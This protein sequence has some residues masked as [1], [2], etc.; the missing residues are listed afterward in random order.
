MKKEAVIVVD[1]QNSFANKET[2]SLYVNWWENIAEAINE[3]VRE[4][5]AKWWIVITS[6]EIHP[7]WHI[8]FATSFEW[9]ESI[10]EAFKRW[11]A[12]SAKNF[13]TKDEIANWTPKNN[14]IAK[15]ASFNLQEL[16]AYLEISW[17]QALWPE[18]CVDKTPWADFYR[19]LDTTKIDIEIKK[20]YKP[21]SHPYSAFE[22]KTLDEKESTIEVIKRL[23]VNLVKVVWLATDYCDI[24]TVLDARKEGIETEFVEKA[25]AWV[26]SAWTI[27]ALKKMREVWAKI[28]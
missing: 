8:S 22:W 4:V 2:G 16:K 17:D 5:K 11:E 25:S 19:D 14:W 26:D 12:P 23:W 6:R 1:Y 15:W 3:V 7:V 13:I 28:I 21:D 10:I 9:K 20:W 24:A 27:E 18:H